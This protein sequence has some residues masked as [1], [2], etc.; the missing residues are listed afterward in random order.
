MNNF[1]NQYTPKQFW[2]EFGCYSVDFYPFEDQQLN[3]HDPT[4][5]LNESE[6]QDRIKEYF[7]STVYQGI[8]YFFE[9]PACL[10]KFCEYIENLSE[11]AERVSGEDNNSD[12]DAILEDDY[13]VTA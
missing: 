6:Y 2:E 10:Q 11:R 5:G 3:E 7:Y 12:N 1:Y 8:R 4:R 9:E 13:I